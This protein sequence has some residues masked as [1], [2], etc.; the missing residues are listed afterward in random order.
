MLNP[1]LICYQLIFFLICYVKLSER[2][3]NRNLV[4]LGLAI[5]FDYLVGISYFFPAFIKA[6]TCFCL[7][8]SSFFMA[9]LVSSVPSAK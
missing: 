6:L 3:F 4:S 5:S 8:F 1:I 7:S 9:L 2:R